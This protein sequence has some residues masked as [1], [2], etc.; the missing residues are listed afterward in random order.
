MSTLDEPRKKLEKIGSLWDKTSQKDGLPYMS[1][2]VKLQDK[3]YHI[4]VFMNNKRTNDKQP[5]WNIMTDE[6]TGNTPFQR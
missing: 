3:E 5:N 2:V 1:G 4:R 6:E